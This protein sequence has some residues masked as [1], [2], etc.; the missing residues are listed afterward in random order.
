M[1]CWHVHSETHVWTSARRMQDG[2]RAAGPCVRESATLMLRTNVRAGTDLLRS[3]GS[4]SLRGGFVARVWVPRALAMRGLRRASIR[5]GYAEVERR[6][7]RRCCRRGKRCAVRAGV[8]DVRAHQHACVRRRRRGGRRQGISEAT[9]DARRTTHEKRLLV[10]DGEQ[11][12][13]DASKTDTGA[14]RERESDGQMGHG[15][16]A[17]ADRRVGRRADSVS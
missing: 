14:E 6:L 8:G 1:G 16:E 4:S 9:H 15:C 7:V 17:S 2:R 13:L 11:R 3:R 12:N 5:R 10:Q